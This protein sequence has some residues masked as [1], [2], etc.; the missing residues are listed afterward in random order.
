MCLIPNR[1]HI[2]VQGQT[3]TRTLAWS[4]ISTRFSCFIGQLLSINIKLWFPT[5]FVQKLLFVCLFLRNPKRRSCPYQ[6]QWEPGWECSFG[7]R[8]ML[9]E[10]FPCAL[11]G[12]LVGSSCNWEFA[13]ECVWVCHSS[14]LYVV[15]LVGVNCPFFWHIFL[16][17]LVTF[18]KLGLV[19]IFLFLSV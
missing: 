15:A 13:C 9:C 6:R 14:L 12:W 11:V 7:L 4:R 18:W 8:H 10:R 16:L 2:K 19:I 3:Q 5:V 1:F 17:F